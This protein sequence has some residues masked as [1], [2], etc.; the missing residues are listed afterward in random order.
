MLDAFAN[1]H[2]QPTT[3]I[4]P[5][6]T[7]DVD[8]D[9]LLNSLTAEQRIVYDSVLN[10]LHTRVDDVPKARLFYLDGPAGTGKSYLINTIYR[11]AVSQG[12]K[13]TTATTT[14]ISA[15]LIPRG[16]TMHRVFGIPIELKPQS[17]SSITANSP[18]GADLTQTDLFI[19]DEISIARKEHLFIADELLK[20]LTSLDI[21][22]G[23]KVVLFAGDLRQSTPIIRGASRTEVID[24]CVFKYDQWPAVEQ[25][26]LHQ[27]VRTDPDQADYARTLLHIGNGGSDPSC[28]APFVF[29]TDHVD[30]DAS[31]FTSS[32][33]AL[34]ETTFG[35]CINTDTPP[36]TFGRA[37]LTPTNSMSM[38]L[39]ER[40]LETLNTSQQVQY[41]HGITTQQLQKPTGQRESIR[42]GH[43]HNKHSPRLFGISN[44]SRMSTPHLASKSKRRCYDL[45]HHRR[46]SRIV[47]W[48]NN[49]TNTSTPT[50]PSW[51]YTNWSFYW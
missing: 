36:D 29:T 8:P 20:D 50:L 5:D 28:N 41:L 15:T 49:N 3:E 30:L 11:N 2:N 19:I 7:D 18:Q 25:L 35:D 42:P 39:S 16:Q 22:W 51:N 46:K 38:E 40:I 34:I 14:G 9:D 4:N 33:D 23:G 47:Q 17:R 10:A 6:E 26:K 37:I 24:K 31:M 43:S 44:P 13:V 45:A 12:F 32:L 21:P 48:H 27:N 1:R